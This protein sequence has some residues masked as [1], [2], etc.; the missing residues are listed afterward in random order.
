MKTSEVF[1]LARSMI[2]SAPSPQQ[3][4]FIC[5]AIYRLQFVSAYDRGRA[6]DII[7]NRL[8]PSKTVEGWISRRLPKDAN[9]ATDKDFYEFRIRWLKALEEEFKQRGD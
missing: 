2:E 9:A 6:L 4:P 1:R 7:Q 3:C 5:R 8:F